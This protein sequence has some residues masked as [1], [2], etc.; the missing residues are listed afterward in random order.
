MPQEMSG[1]IEFRNV[2]FRYPTRPDQHI[3][4]K[5]SATF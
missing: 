4:Q 5:F 2:D 1:K 3:I